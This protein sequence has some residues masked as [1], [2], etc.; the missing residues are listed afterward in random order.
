MCGAVICAGNRVAR[1]KQFAEQIQSDLGRPVFPAKITR[2]PVTPN[3]WF[4]PHCLVSARGAFRDRHE[5]EMGCGGRDSVGAQGGRRVSWSSWAA[6]GAQDERR[7]R[8]RQNRVV[9]TPVA[10]A[11][12]RGGE[13][14]STELD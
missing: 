13:I 8:V 11:K 7:W 3:Q 14:N 9:L 10:G 6:H 4:F 2:F 12:L 5:R 1:K